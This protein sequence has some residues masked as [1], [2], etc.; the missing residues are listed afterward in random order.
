MKVTAGIELLV[1]L[2][3]DGAL[4]LRGPLQQQLRGAG[5]S[6]GLRPGSVLP[7]TR[8]LAAELAVAR[9]VIS[10]A[11]AQLA[12]EGYLV[13]R[14]GAPT[15]VADSVRTQV[16]PAR[17]GASEHRWRYDFRPGAPDGALF[18]RLLWSGA[19]ADALRTVPDARFDYGDPRGTPE[20]RTALASYLG[21][22]R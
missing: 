8:A 14:Q 4:P 3:R 15:R 2:D 12:A 11:Y 22:V 17:P 21:R 19:L 16:T 1:R 20:L 7:A 5:R 9:N 18:P 10:D 6:G 13:S